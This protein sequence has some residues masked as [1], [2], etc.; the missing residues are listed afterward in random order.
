M[1]DNVRVP[2]IKEIKTIVLKKKICGRCGE[3]FNRIGYYQRICEDC[4]MSRGS[5]AWKQ[6]RSRH[7]VPIEPIRIF[8]EKQ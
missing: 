2:Y 1:L 6:E 5:K 7:G 3:I 4:N 8:R